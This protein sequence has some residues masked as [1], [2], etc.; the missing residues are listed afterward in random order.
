MLAQHED[1]CMD[2]LLWRHAEAHELHEGQTDLERALTTKG[3]K[4]AQRV[5]KWLDHQL[6]EGARVYCSPA[7]R[8]VQ[9]V[10]RLGRPYKVRDALSPGA[11]VQ[12][13]LDC[14]RWPEARYPVLV[15]G[16]QPVLG[17]VIAQVLGLSGADLSVRKGA[18]WW[19]RRRIRE[20]QVQ[21]VVMSVICP[22][23]L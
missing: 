16:H 1:A 2:L 14:V 9:T 8:T 18:L 7:V 12:D 13:V 11:S 15:V 6:P 21:T 3:E 17:Q 10:E 19:L 5:A 4:Q 23:H 20:G 22:E